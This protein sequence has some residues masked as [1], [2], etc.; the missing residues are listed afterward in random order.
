M[1]IAE[2][3]ENIVH[4]LENII[5]RAEIIERQNGTR[6]LLEID[7]AMEDVRFLY[8]EMERL[9][10]LTEA[11]TL[12]ASMPGET[13]SRPSEKQEPP[14]TP[15]QATSKNTTPKPDTQPQRVDHTSAPLPQPESASTDEQAP[16]QETL[17]Q[18]PARETAP[19]EKTQPVKQESA[20]V[21]DSKPTEDKETP[22][23]TITTPQ[24]AQK[25]QE[26]KVSADTTK[27]A[28]ESETPKTP[29]P[30]TAE[31][32]E[33]KEP[34]MEQPVATSSPKINEITKKA[35]EKAT[36][37]AVADLF[38]Q[39]K[40]I[41]GEKFS[42]DKSS[43]HERLA[44]IKEDVSIGTRMQHKPIANIKDAIGL[45]EKFLFINELFNGDLNAYNES[46]AELNTFP[47]IHEA[48]EYLNLLTTQFQWDGQRSAETIEKFANLVQR[49]YMQ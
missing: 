45:N 20:P 29:E 30:T 11:E 41:V 17:P 13:M 1:R 19:S 42:S 31:N 7:L 8:R 6:N 16:V 36:P 37:K 12:H 3:K 15:V 4:L 44:Q 43:V 28:T 27:P 14:K 49:R 22:K 39:E 21:D 25:E 26:E 34:K 5:K 10:K 48:F 24:P 46:V 38:S 40:I 47:S 9:R 33:K 18:P 32:T 23:E 35:A 2:I